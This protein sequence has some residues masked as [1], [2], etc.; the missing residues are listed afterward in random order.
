VKCLELYIG[1]RKQVSLQA[2]LDQVGHPDPDKPHIP[3][4]CGQGLVQQDLGSLEYRLSASI[5]SLNDR[6][7]VIAVKSANLTFIASIVSLS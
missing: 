6:L 7:W 5:P 2:L 1:R 3:P 4:L